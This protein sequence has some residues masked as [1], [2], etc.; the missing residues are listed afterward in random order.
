[1]KRSKQFYIRRAHRYLGLFI[2]IQFIA[3]TIS[4]LYFSWNQIDDVHGDHLRKQQ[5]EFSADMD[6]VS[7]K[8]ALRHIADSRNID[9]VKN[10]RL[11]NVLNEPTYQIAYYDGVEHTVTS[12]HAPLHYALAIARSG[13]LR[14]PLTQEEAVAVAR[15][16]LIAPSTISD[17]EFI[18]SSHGHHEYRGGRLPAYAITFESPE[19][20]IYVNPEMGNFQTIRHNQ[21]RLFDFLWMFHTMDYAGRDNFNNWLLRIFSVFGFITVASGFVLYFISSPTFKKLF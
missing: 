15:E 21:W 1:M 6:L 17:I 2:G 19:C 9:S 14:A 12:H 8:I 16:Q 4:G 20:T 11:I 5:S 10:I 7:P 18:Q 13:Q 3:W